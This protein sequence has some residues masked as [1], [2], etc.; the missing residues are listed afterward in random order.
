[1]PLLDMN[2]GCCCQNLP[3]LPIALCLCKFTADLLSHPSAF[4]DNHC[5]GAAPHLP[6]LQ[7]LADVRQV[8][9]AAAGVDN[10]VQLLAINLPVWIAA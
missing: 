3:V 2:S 10:D 7:V 9:L 6:V 1:M 4:A 8:L 5:A